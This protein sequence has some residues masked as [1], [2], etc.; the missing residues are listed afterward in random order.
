MF[1]LTLLLAGCQ[2]I[3]NGFDV[4]QPSV[5]T[6][7]ITLYE[8]PTTKITF[9]VETPA[10]I[11]P[12]QEVMIE[13]LDELTGLAVAPDRRLMERIDLTHFTLTTDVIGN[14]V[15]KYRYFRRGENPSLEYN[16]LN[17]PV[18]YRFIFANHLSEVRDQITGWN[19]FSDSE[20]FGVIEGQILDKVSNQ[21]VAGILVSCGGD[22]YI[23]TADGYFRFG[24]IR[25]GYNTLSA[26]SMDGKYLPFQQEAIVAD[27]SLTPAQFLMQPADFSEVTFVLDASNF[28]A[29]NNAIRIIG[30]L[31]QTGNTFSDLGGQQSVLAILAPSMDAKGEGKY[32]AK[33][34]LPIGMIFS[35][36]YSLGDG[37]WNSERMADGSFYSRNILINDKVEIIQDEITNWYQPDSA[38]V[39]FVLEIPQNTPT[40]DLIS[41]QFNPFEWSPPIPMWKNGDNQ[42]RYILF[43]PQDLLGEISYR[44]CRND[45]CDNTIFISN[46]ASPSSSGSFHS[47]PG[48]QLH[49]DK[50]EYWVD[51]Q[52]S[53]TPTIV[54]ST[55]PSSRPVEFSSGF[56]IQADYEPGSKTFIHNG[57]GAIS[58]SGANT[59]LITP[60]WQLMMNSPAVI[61]QVPGKNPSVSEINEIISRAKEQQMLVSLFPRILS[62]QNAS[63]ISLDSVDQ[64]LW[65]ETIQR[66]YIHF[67]TIASQNNAESLIVD[68][69][70]L[71]WSN[72]KFINELLAKIRIAYQ[73]KVII[74]VNYADLS[75]YSE[76][77]VSQFDG[78]YLLLECPLFDGITL[79]VNS[80]SEKV[81]QI[82]DQ[83]IYP[84]AAKN[85][86]QLI[87]GVNFPSI[88]SSGSVCY[89]TSKEVSEAQTENP[90][91]S[92]APAN[93]QSQTDI[94]N[95]I[96]SSIVTRDWISGVI[97][98]GYSLASARTDNSSSVHGKPASDILWYWYTKLN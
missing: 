33:I 91:L 6:T 23:S 20:Q 49:N 10:E 18:R 16:Y 68:G 64:D 53:E 72:D 89:K 62:D 47:D 12:G 7:E 63:D 79:D 96:F 66:Y 39:N 34:Y 9:F 92:D 29:P 50:I 21:P 56:E 35:Y 14:S 81:S 76:D 15:I 44:Y 24:R 48:I 59:L 36:K 83:D 90:F 40:N 28:S 51:L 67:A 30:N 52:P 97:S 93:L 5:E 25:P 78:I 42:Y 77:L 26:I 32:Q 4:Q 41:I 58:Q 98:R 94:Y 11:T 60:S 54:L 37:L 71:E 61:K 85:N 8:L 27:N 95:A 70:Y 73:Q 13:F 22:Q 75:E 55:E 69:K 2:T 86:K 17:K 43:S 65:N 19:N 45:K 46:N 88:D 82:L 38:S 31:S 3:I 80:A 74:A 57:F 84:I 1:V 87:I